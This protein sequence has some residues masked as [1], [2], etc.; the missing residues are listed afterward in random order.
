MDTLS[1]EA[2]LCLLFLPVH[3]EGRILGGMF[4]KEFP[5]LRRND[6]S[7]PEVCIWGEGDIGLSLDPI[8]I[9]MTV[10]CSYGISG[11]FLPTCIDI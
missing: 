10:P 4:R 7:P 2:P 11:E 8:G 9:G 6:V 1:R 5:P 3:G